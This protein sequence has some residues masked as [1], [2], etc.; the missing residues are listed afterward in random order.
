MDDYCSGEVIT[1]A[2]EL[3]AVLGRARSMYSR[4]RFSGKA[5]AVV[6]V[7][8]LSEFPL[9]R[10][11]LPPTFTNKKAVSNKENFE[12]DN[13]CTAQVTHKLFKESERG[14]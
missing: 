12:I 13:L 7:F 14:S 10:T 11:G 8:Q 5:W 3:A 6:I 1:L 4:V 2:N 9:N